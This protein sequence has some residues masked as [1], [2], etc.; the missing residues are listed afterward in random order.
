MIRRQVVQ[1]KPLTVFITMKKMLSIIFLGYALCLTAT[2]VPTSNRV[3]AANMPE[4]IAPVHAPFAMVQPVKPV[5]PD[6]SVDISKRGAKPG[7]LCTKVI[8]KAIDELSQKGGGT[9]V[10]PS[11]R[12]STGRVTLKS[13]INL[14]LEEG[15]ELHFSG[16][17]KDYLPVVFT[18][19][20][21]IELYSLGAMI[22]ADGASNIA[23]TGKGKL[24]G[25][26]KECEIYTKQMRDMVIE[27]FI[28][29]DTPVAER[30]YD[31]KEGKPVFLPMFFSPINSENI[32]VEGVTF[33]ETLFWNIVPVYCNNI[34]IR[35]VTVNSF[36]TPRGDGIDID[37]SANVLVEY[38]TLDCGDDCF[39]IKA[40][41]AEDGIRVNRPSE[42]I[43]IRHCL[44]KRG[45]GGV[46][47]GSETAGKIRNVYM[48]DC[49]FEKTRNGFYFKTRRNRGGGGENIYFERIRLVSPKNA[50]YW[51]MLGSEMYVG[52]LARR[53][54]APPVGRLTP[55]YRDISIK[56]IV[57]E[58]CEYL[59]RA[60]GIPE[61]PLS[62]VV[63]NNMNAK[64]KNFLMLQ[65]VDG[66]VMANSSITSENNKVSVVDG[67]NIMLIDTEINTPGGKPDIEYSGELAR[68][69]MYS[70]G[71]C[72]K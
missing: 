37:S 30:I 9:V 23:L 26:S 18:R 54:P 44:A 60:T 63:I 19:N 14:H 53:L 15:A 64:C 69:V 71:D 3:G 62:G 39:T 42:N 24:V 56:D 28:P 48:H 33:E 20:E 52:E 16:E 29:A 65:D 13:N 10:V 72:A 38:T 31:G 41:R 59:I 32:L 61:I 55:F 6:R 47:L 51:D 21:G 5:F 2:E 34:I 58:H 50:F 7:K 66:F 57:V 70:G 12:W 4:E 8:Q 1:H 49:V 11:G 43:V 36:G 22:Y 27:D 46:T 35:G 25:P 17:I 45:P 40:G 67:R 68:P